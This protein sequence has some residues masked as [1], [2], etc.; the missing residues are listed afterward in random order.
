MAF[1]SGIVSLLPIHLTIENTEVHQLKHFIRYFKSDS[2][3][4]LMALNRSPLKI[5]VI[6]SMPN[7]S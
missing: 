2:F 1:Q 7:K 6:H 3:P 4:I 5:Y